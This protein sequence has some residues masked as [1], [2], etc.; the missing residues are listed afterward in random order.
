[1]EEASLEFFPAG[2]KEY[3]LGGSAKESFEAAVK[4]KVHK[5]WFAM[6]DLVE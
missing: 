3:M 1:M 5:L 2:Q 6:G 4:P